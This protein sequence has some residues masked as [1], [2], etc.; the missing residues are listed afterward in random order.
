MVFGREKA[1]MLNSEGIAALYVS[2]RYV[3]R[4]STNSPK[5]T[6]EKAV[7][8]RT[9]CEFWLFSLQICNSGPSLAYVL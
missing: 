6:T 3:A 2:S 9:I 4:W 8:Y 1:E 5:L 7:V